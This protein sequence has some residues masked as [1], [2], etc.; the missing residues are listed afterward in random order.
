[1]APVLGICFFDFPALNPPLQKGGFW[2]SACAGM[3]QN[4]VDDNIHSERMCG[5][6][7]LDKRVGQRR[8]PT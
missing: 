8:M 6:E 1:M 3:T 4:A 7:G 5:K 2:I